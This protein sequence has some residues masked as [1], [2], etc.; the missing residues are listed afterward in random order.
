MNVIEALLLDASAPEA[1]LN[2]T[3]NAVAFYRS[4]DTATKS[5]P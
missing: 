3:L 4:S 2:A 1:R 5:R